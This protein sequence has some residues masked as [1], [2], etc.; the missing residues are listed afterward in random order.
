[1]S[2]WISVKDRLPK[3]GQLVLICTAGIKD[4]ASFTDF[5]FP[6]YRKWALQGMTF[7]PTHWMPL[8]EPP[9]D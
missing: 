3:D 4:A 8:P 7:H 5:Y 1:M 2:E 9:N 6:K